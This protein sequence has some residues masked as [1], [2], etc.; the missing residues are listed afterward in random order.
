MGSLVTTK[1]LTGCN[2]S[3]TFSPNATPPL[4]K[5]TLQTA[6]TLPFGEERFI[7]NSLPPTQQTTHQQAKPQ[8]TPCSWINPIAVSAIYPT[9][10]WTA[11]IFGWASSL[12]PCFLRQ[13]IFHPL[14]LGLKH[15]V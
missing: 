12:V 4:L 2:L 8:K 15:L 14:H 1:R 3:I 7:Y 13:Q 11:Y 5:K 6:E 10:R 9:K